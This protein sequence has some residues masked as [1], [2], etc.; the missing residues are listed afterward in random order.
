MHGWAL[1]GMWSE[2]EIEKLDEIIKKKIAE[3]LS[4]ESL[5]PIVERYLNEN[6]SVFEIKGKGENRADEVVERIESQSSRLTELIQEYLN[7]VE[8]VKRHR[9][10]SPENKLKR[11]IPPL[12]EIQKIIFPNYYPKY[13]QF[14]DDTYIDLRKELDLENLR[15]NPK[16]YFIH[17][18]TEFKKLGRLDTRHKNIVLRDQ[19]VSATFSVSQIYK[20]CLADLDQETIKRKDLLT[21]ILVCYTIKRALNGDEEAIKKLCSLYEDVAQAIAVKTGNSIAKKMGMKL[22]DPI[23]IE[24]MKHDAVTLLRF[25]VAGFRPDYILEQLLKDKGNR[26]IM[27]FPQ[28][29]KGFYIYYLSEY[30]PQR[31]TAILIK[32]EEID[33][34][35]RFANDLSSGAISITDLLK[36]EKCAKKTVERLQNSNI[37]DVV[38]WLKSKTQALGLEVI[39]LLNLYAP[40]Q[41]GTAWKD[42][43]KRKNWFNNYSFRPGKKLMGPRWNLKTWLFATRYGKVYQLLRNK[44]KSIIK[45][46][47]KTKHFDFMDEVD[48]DHKETLNAED[49]KKAL[50]IEDLGAEENKLVDKITAKEEMEI[51]RK[52]LL[53]LGVP[54]R[55]IKIYFRWNSDDRPTQSKVA[56]E[57]GLSLRQIGRIC[58][59]IEKLIPKVKHRIHEE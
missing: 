9:K 12:S 33:R 1:M 11:L 43:P 46:R 23:T 5:H 50:G 21:Q 25:L 6:P 4:P 13:H 22:D 16:R 59:Q 29:V 36:Q 58:Q 49:R 34:L 39:A 56:Q 32:S 15:G 28:W 31:L 24:D 48:E 2:M 47:L 54:A 30:V 20:E 14:V 40:I 42:T 44:Y 38:E 51:A 18:T 52:G 45:D 7:A 57:Y 35:I 41:D 55:N 37:E 8:E 10:F 17:Q 19:S 27:V 53:D 3:A 26:T